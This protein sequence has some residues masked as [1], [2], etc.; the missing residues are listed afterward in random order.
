MADNAYFESLIDLIKLES[1]EE[2]VKIRN[3]IMK[4][5][6]TEGTVTASRIPAPRN[7]TELG[8]YI[9]LLSTLKEDEMLRQT[10]ASALGVSYLS[11]SKDL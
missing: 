10:L 6:A 7:I 2:A 9:N 3:L 11:M 1:S 5:I 4:R 8:G